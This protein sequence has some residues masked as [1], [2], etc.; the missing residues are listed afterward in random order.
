MESRQPTHHGWAVNVK[1]RGRPYGAD[2]VDEA[3]GI[4][5]DD[6][7]EAVYRQAQEG[8]WLDLTEIAQ[9]DHG[10]TDVYSEGRSGGWAVPHPQPDEDDPAD[11]ARF[12]AFERAALA[13]M[14][15]A[16][17]HFAELLAER[18]AEV[19]A[20]RDEVK[21]TPPLGAQV[22]RSDYYPLR[23]VIGELVLTPAGN[24]SLRIGREIDEAGRWGQTEYV[25]LTPDEVRRLARRLG[26][27][28]GEEVSA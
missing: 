22:D 19:E 17:E 13:L 16:R 20:E 2:E 10:F 9:A 7:I 4:L 27:L 23:S 8:Y 12:R 25:T 14:D 18:V 21:R 26:E 28:I 3:R 24:V 15:D 5:T 1:D 6:E 11:V